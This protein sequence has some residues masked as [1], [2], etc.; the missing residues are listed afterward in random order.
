M[1]K[2][3]IIK[4]SILLAAMAVVFTAG[5]ALA[6][7]EE[8]SYMYVDACMSGG[9]LTVD[10]GFLK[11]TDNAKLLLPLYDEN[12][13][14]SGVRAARETDGAYVFEIGEL[15]EKSKLCVLNTANENGFYRL[16]L[17]EYAE[18]KQETE[19]SENTENTETIVSTDLTDSSLKDENEEW[20]YNGYYDYWNGNSSNDDN[21]DNNNDDNDEKRICSISVDCSRALEYEGIESEISAILPQDGQIIPYTE[22]E[23]T[24]NMSA[25]DVLLQ[26]ASKNNIAIDG[27]SSYVSG[28]NGLSEFD[29]GALSGWMYSVNGDF[30]NVP[31]NEYTVSENDE[32]KLMYTCDMGNDLK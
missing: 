27:D 17:I 18:N 4:N 8:N 23:I 32:I 3:K 10:K 5:T 21:N 16:N 30:P 20:G 31:M 2:T 19:N 1:K 7:N 25:Y 6:Q 13:V 24:E 28:I 29:C 9:A 26:A 22:V 12:G 11:D 15:S 14:L